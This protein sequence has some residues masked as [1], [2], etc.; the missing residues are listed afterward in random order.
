MVLHED[1]PLPV[2][3][4]GPPRGKLHG[5]ATKLIAAFIF[6]FVGIEAGSPISSWLECMCEV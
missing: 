6:G 5:A 2:R 4:R 3:R 1:V